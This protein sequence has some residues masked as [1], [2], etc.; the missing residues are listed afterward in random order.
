MRCHTV[1]KQIDLRI[2]Q[3]LQV[4]PLLLGSFHE[5]LLVAFKLALIYLY[6]V[7]LAFANKKKELEIY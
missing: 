4:S 3:L 5:Q 7:A 1:P 2:G 6:V